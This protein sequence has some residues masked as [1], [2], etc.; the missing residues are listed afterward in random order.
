MVWGEC[1]DLPPHGWAAAVSLD[2]KAYVAVEVVVNGNCRHVAIELLYCRHPWTHHCHY[3][4]HRCHCY[5][6]YR[7]KLL[8]LP[9]ML[10]LW[11]LCYLCYC[12]YYWHHYCKYDYYLALRCSLGILHYLAL[13]VA[14]H[15]DLLHTVNDAVGA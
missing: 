10:L 3:C 14:V 13:I 1:A 11:Y 15:V 12:R 6:C 5:Y 9:L 2:E 4:D 8:H 7:L